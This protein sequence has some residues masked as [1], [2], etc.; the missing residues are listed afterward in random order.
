[1]RR[2][3]PLARRADA[4]AVAGVVAKPCTVNCS[5]PDFGENF[6]WPKAGDGSGWVTHASMR[7]VPWMALLHRPRANRFQSAPEPPLALN[8]SAELAL[9]MQLPGGPPQPRRPG[10]VNMNTGALLAAPTSSRAGQ[11]SR[12]AVCMAGQARTLA[13]PAV[14]RS[15]FDNL[16]V[17]GR[18]DLFAVLRTGSE[19]CPKGCPDKRAAGFGISMQQFNDMELAAPCHVERAL[20]ALRPVRVRFLHEADAAPCAENYATLQAP[21]D[22]GLGERGVGERGATERGDGEGRRRGG[23]GEEV[24]WGGDDVG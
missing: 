11:R 16:L 13:H 23:G 8:G 1:M 10:A 7:E 21:R 3:R 18:H 22:E 15:A 12:I 17:Q 2:W 4:N 20:R 6:P 19:G 24:G 14:W 9:R 5:L